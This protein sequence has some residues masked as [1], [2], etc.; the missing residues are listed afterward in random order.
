MDKV[1]KGTAVTTVKELRAALAR[2]ED[3]EPINGRITQG[4]N[5]I[6]YIIPVVSGLDGKKGVVIDLS[7]ENQV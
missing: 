1:L 3:D 2:F 4:G 7:D 5:S 6:A